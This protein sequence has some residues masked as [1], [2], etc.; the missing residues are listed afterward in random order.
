MTSKNLTRHP[1]ALSIRYKI[2]SYRVSIAPDAVGEVRRCKRQMGLSWG[3]GVRL[4]QVAGGVEATGLTAIEA[5]AIL[6]AIEKDLEVLR[7]FNR[8]VDRL[9]IRF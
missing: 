7:E 6:A 2:V 4:D 9:E 1:V 8:R 5:D 3:E